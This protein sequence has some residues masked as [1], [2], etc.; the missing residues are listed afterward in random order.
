MLTLER[1]RGTSGGR[2]DHHHV[3][4]HAHRAYEHTM[5]VTEDGVDTGHFPRP[6]RTSARKLEGTGRADNS[7]APEQR[8]TVNRRDRS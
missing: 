3:L 5:V 8:Q 7:A 6:R 2:L 4:P 1:L